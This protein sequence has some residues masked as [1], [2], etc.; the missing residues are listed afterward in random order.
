MGCD[1]KAIRLRWGPIML[2]TEG[3]DVS[4]DLLLSGDFAGVREISGTLT[5]LGASGTS[6]TLDVKLV[7][8][9][10]NTDIFF[11]A[12]PS[13]GF[14]QVTSAGSAPVKV[15]LTQFSQYVNFKYT[16]GGTDPKFSVIIDLIGKG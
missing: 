13:G 10:E 8:A 14:A 3:S 11:A 5:V 2:S 1:S 4:N 12:T 9:P 16:L 6:P 15:Y 7:D